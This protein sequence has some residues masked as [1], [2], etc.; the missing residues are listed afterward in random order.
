LF[1]LRVSDLLDCPVG[2][3]VSARFGNHNRSD[4][5]EEIQL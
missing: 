4:G 2:G 1:L 3:L 5:P